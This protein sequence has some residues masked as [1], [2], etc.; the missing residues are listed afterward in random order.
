MIASGITCWPDKTS[1]QSTGKEGFEPPTNALEV[2]GSIQ[3]SYLPIK[4]RGEELPF[5]L[6]SDIIRHLGQS[7]N[8]L[9]L[10]LLP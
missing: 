2:R 6:N 8:P 4:L 3:L 1:I 7:V 9:L 10:M 5:P